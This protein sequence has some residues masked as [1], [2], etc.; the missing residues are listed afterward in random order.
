ME[1]VWK[2][3]L[4]F[5]GLYQ[6]SSLGRI[7]SLDRCY[8][9]K[10]QY[11]SEFNVVRK[12]GIIRDRQKKGSKYR[13]IGLR[14]NGKRYW[15]FV[16]RLVYEAFNGPIPPGMQINH[17]DENPENNCVDNLNLL[18][19]KENSNWGSHNQKISDAQTGIKNSFYGKHPSD[20][21]IQRTKETHNKPV[22]Q[23]TKDMTLLARYESIEEAS[24]ICGIPSPNISAVCNHYRW[25]F[26]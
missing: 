15:F 23:Y 18:T 1:E 25:E 26:A 9:G 6:V 3:V 4:G 16:H 19:Q 14:K 12:G 21:C 2:D 11:G 17:I 22:L 24:T 20:C 7:R 13:R 8:I 10:N 5:E